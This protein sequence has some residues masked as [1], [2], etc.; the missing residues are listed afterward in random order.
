[1]LVVILYFWYRVM[2]KRWVTGRSGEEDS[3]DGEG[4]D[5]K[6]SVDGNEKDIDNDDDDTVDDID[7]DHTDDGGYSTTDQRSEAPRR[8]TNRGPRSDERIRST[9]ENNRWEKY[10]LLFRTS[11]ERP[12]SAPYLRLKI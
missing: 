6:V 3:S 10:L 7:N 12:K 2:L 8:T 1:M 5:I 4:E 9:D 11:R